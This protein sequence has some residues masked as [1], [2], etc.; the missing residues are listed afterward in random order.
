MISI[1]DERFDLV[2]LT[3]IQISNVTSIH[4]YYILLILWKFS[5]FCMFKYLKM[6]IYIFVKDL[7]NFLLEKEN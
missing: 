6:L 4:I 3:C 2:D 5:D 1:I 7:C